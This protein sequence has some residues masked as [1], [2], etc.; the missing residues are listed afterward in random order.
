MIHELGAVMTQAIGFPNYGSFG[1]LGTARL[2]KS[3]FDVLVE[4]PGS[5][6]HQRVAEIPQAVHHAADAGLVWPKSKWS[7]FEQGPS[8]RL[9]DWWFGT[10]FIFPYIG[11]NHPN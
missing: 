4:I 9:T 1:E 10:F 7:D 8:K 11:N 3:R 5:L 2:P 6:C